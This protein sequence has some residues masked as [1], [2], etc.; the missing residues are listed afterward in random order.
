MTPVGFLVPTKTALK[1]SIIDAHHSF[2]SFL[3]DTG[4]HDFDEQL[5][6]PGHKKL[7][8]TTLYSGGHR[9]KTKSS[10]YRPVTK[11]GDPRIW[12]Y[13]LG[14]NTDPT[15][16]IAV[17]YV[18]GRR[19]IAIN[20]SNQNLENLLLKYHEDFAM[21]GREPELAMSPSA[22]ELL[23]KLN[24]VSAQGWVQNLREGDTGVGYTL[25]TLLGIEAN[26]SKEPDYKG[27]ELKASREGGRSKQATL[28]S[29]VPDWELSALK[30][31]RDILLKL[32]RFNEE[33]NR[34]QLFHEI[35]CIKPN[36]YGLQLELEAAS[37]ILHQV[38]YHTLDDGVEQKHY[39][40]LWQMATLHD[41]IREKHR[42]TM[43]VSADTRGKRSEE[44]FWYR[45]ARYTTGFDSSAVQL[46]LDAGYLTVHYLIRQ[47][48]SGAAK[49]QGYLFKMSGK[50]LPLLFSHSRQFELGQV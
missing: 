16:L 21:F 19:F 8:E 5:Q 2:R 32:G 9:I 46:L 48:P 45:M 15:D 33:K 18:E 40:V 37:P 3:V 35:S 49:D 30:S 10:L 7:I 39:D 11:S 24:E 27:I 41:R 23:E 50:Y 13:E 22:Q 42:E 6:G 28:F 4:A 20:C 38:S 1:K 43:W 44:E 26:S 25:E 29:Q 31:S 47:L 34:L 12:I 36:S 14:K 17:L